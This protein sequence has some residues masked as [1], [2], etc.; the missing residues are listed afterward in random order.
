MYKIKI[1][2]KNES[3]N[4]LSHKFIGYLYES[5]DKT[6]AKKIVGKNYVKCR[7]I[8]FLFVIPRRRQNKHMAHLMVRGYRVAATYLLQKKSKCRQ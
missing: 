6:G 3:I 5:G 8:F 1:R 2:I 4:Y 7:R